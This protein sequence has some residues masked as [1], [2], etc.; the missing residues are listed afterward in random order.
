MGTE[1]EISAADRLVQFRA[2]SPKFRGQSFSAISGAGE[3]GAIIHYRVTPAS[4][5]PI[6]PDEL[7]L[8]DSGAQ[9]LDGTTDVTRT[10]W[11]GVNNPP[12]ELRDRYTRVLKGLI[13]IDRA[14]FPTGTA[15]VHLD[16]LA[17][18]ALWEVGLDFDHGTGHGIGS[19]LAVHEGPASISRPLR[20]A[21]L[22]PGMIMSD[23]PGYYL[24]GAYG[25]RLENLIVVQRA[26]L[27]GA[28]KPF[29]RF[30][31][32]TLAPFEARLIDTDL[33][34]RED[35]QWI[36]SYHARVRK[37]IGPLLE[38]P[39]RAW[40]EAACAPLSTTQPARE[41]GPKTD[42]ADQ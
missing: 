25:I 37:L 6:R 39:T 13:A 21:T 36:N 1:T 9:Y 15:G 27:P 8:I 23:E 12:T 30:E 29:Y 2:M 10:V 33:L 5:R 20:P 17:R 42:N 19:Y 11:T 34:T 24:P 40:L 28:L 18:S 7:Y 32:L 26:D 3:N 38:A 4:N 22:E 14:V 31:T 16:A 41:E 35:I